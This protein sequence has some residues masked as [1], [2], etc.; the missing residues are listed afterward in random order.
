MSVHTVFLCVHTVFLLCFPPTFRRRPGVYL[1]IRLFEPLLL[2]CPPG[3]MRGRM[4]PDQSRSTAVVGITRSRGS[5]CRSPIST[6]ARDSRLTTYGDAGQSGGARVS[7]IFQTTGSSE[8]ARRPG[9][10]THRKVQQRRSAFSLRLTSHAHTTWWTTDFFNSDS[11]NWVTRRHGALDLTVA[12]RPSSLS[13]GRRR[14]DRR[15]GVQGRV[16]AGQG[17]VPALVI[18][19]GRPPSAAPSAPCRTARPS[20]MP[21]T[22]PRSARV[23]ASRPPENAST[24]PPT[25]SFP[26]REHR[27]WWSREGRPKSWCCHSGHET[28]SA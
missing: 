1:Y 3:R 10:V 11:W 7:L 28:Q 21:T 19:A 8:E 22:R 20:C 12:Q 14:G 6:M 23:R 17:D 25:P 4:R 5:K 2:P 9:D 27:R 24:R 18:V 26:G 15:E 16:A 13:G